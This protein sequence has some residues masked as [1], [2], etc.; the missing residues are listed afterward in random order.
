MISY[1]R[2]KI[3]LAKAW[4]DRRHG[5]EGWGLMKAP[6]KVARINIDFYFRSLSEFVE[7]HKAETDYSEDEGI[8]KGYGD[9]YQKD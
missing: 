3:G 7:R 2:L 6:R 4:I 8:E 1:L 9:L 5:R